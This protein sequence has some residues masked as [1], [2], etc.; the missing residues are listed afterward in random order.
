MRRSFPCFFLSLPT[1]LLTHRC[2]SQWP[3]FPTYSFGGALAGSCKAARRGCLHKWGPPRRPEKPSRGG[4]TL[5]VTFRAIQTTDWAIQRSLEVNRDWALT[6]L[7]SF[8]PS[9]ASPAFGTSFQAH[10][11]HLGWNGN[12]ETAKRQT[13]AASWGR[14]TGRGAGEEPAGCSLFAISGWSNMA[15][16]NFWTSSQ[17][18]PGA[19]LDARVC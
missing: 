19:R 14:E 2:L 15:D 13:P 8:P 12:L 3:P 11:G 6:R 9:L 4:R 16:S 1:L 17:N 7:G 18:R 5:S 10:D